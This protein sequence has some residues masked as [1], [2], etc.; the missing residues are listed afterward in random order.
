MY[1]NAYSFGMSSLPGSLSDL[2]V[3]GLPAG[4]AT[5][6]RDTIT[7]CIPFIAIGLH[8]LRAKQA[9]IHWILTIT[10]AG[11]NNDYLPS[12]NG[13]AKDRRGKLP[14]TLLLASSGAWIATYICLIVDFELLTSPQSC[15]SPVDFYGVWRARKLCRT[16]FALLCMI[17]KLLFI[18]QM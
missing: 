7:V 6:V 4:F 9:V 12:A 18:L 15:I 3:N 16:L 14:I 11:G 1:L 8:L 5:C 13:E 17:K 10:L 2:Q